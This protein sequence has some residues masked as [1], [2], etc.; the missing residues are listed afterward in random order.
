MQPLVEA[1][2]LED[3]AVVNAGHVAVAARFA[4]A[5]L[6][7]IRLFAAGERGEQVVANRADVEFVQ[8][9][10]LRRSHKRDQPIAGQANFL[11]AVE[12]VVVGRQL[13]PRLIAIGQA[14]AVQL[15]EQIVGGDQML[16]DGVAQMRQVG[17][18]ER[19]VPVAAIAL[20]AVELGA[21]LIDQVAV[22]AGRHGVLQAG[23]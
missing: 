14:A 9:A 12:V 13:D 4:R 6:V 11:P 10:A 8:M 17:A 7:V 23:G 3:D 16:V 5:D 1:F 20:A 22:R 15:V 21:G 2:L 19:T 18:A